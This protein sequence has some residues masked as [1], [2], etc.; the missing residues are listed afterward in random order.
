MQPEGRPLFDPGNVRINPDLPVDM[1]LG[2]IPVPGGEAGVVTFRQ[3]NT[4][5]TLFLDRES[6][7]QFGD[8]FHQLRDN[9]SGSGKLATAVKSPLA[10]GIPGQRL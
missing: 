2:K 7:G 9:L 5:M 10:Q 6:A 4:T 1:D 8:L 3:G